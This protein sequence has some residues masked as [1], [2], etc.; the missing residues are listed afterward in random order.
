MDTI[1][2]AQMFVQ[3][4][5]LAK[6][7]AETDK[8]IQKAVLELGESQ[9]IAGVKATYYKAGEETPDYESAV[10]SHPDFKAIDVAPYTTITETVRWKD[11]ANA[12][13]LEVH[14]APKAARVVVK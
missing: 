4:A 5:E 13:G 6:Q 10:R 12:L 7:L 2:L 9:N 3:R 14:G 8:A 11:I 1:Q